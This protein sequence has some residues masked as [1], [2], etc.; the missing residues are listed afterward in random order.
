M[1]DM[2]DENVQDTV[3][4]VNTVNR[5]TQPIPRDEVEYFLR[6]HKLFRLVEE[7][8]VEEP[9]RKPRKLVKKVIKVEKEE[10]SKPGRYVSSSHISLAYPLSKRKDEGSVKACPSPSEPDTSK[11]RRSTRVEPEPAQPVRPNS[12]ITLTLREMH[13]IVRLFT[14]SPPGCVDWAM[15]SH[16]ATAGRLAP[17]DVEY[18]ANEFLPHVHYRPSVGLVVMERSTRGPSEYQKHRLTLKRMKQGLVPMLARLSPAQP[19]QAVESPPAAEGDSIIT[20]VGS[21]DDHP[22]DTPATASAGPPAST[23]RSID[24]FLS[25]LPGIVLEDLKRRAEMAIQRLERGEV[26]LLAMRATAA[27][28]NETATGRVKR[29]YETKAMRLAKEA[30]TAHI[31]PVPKLEPTAAVVPPFFHATARLFAK[32]SSSVDEI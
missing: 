19:A 2:L 4:V 17:Q 25:G 3:L 11:R 24:S 28:E 31:D 6:K 20:P 7:D 15:I 13:E 16:T 21:P 30:A 18:V 12:L 29:R 27:A 14:S 22:F 32:S 1:T 23:K 26:P 9:K 10:K 5:R 8:K